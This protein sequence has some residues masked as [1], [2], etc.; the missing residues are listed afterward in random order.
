M[1]RSPNITIPRRPLCFPILKKKTANIVKTD[2]VSPLPYHSSIGTW[3]THI[4]LHIFLRGIRIAS[5]HFKLDA[6]TRNSNA[7]I[8]N[9]CAAWARS[10]SWDTLLYYIT[11]I[12][13]P[14]YVQQLCTAERYNRY[15]VTY[16]L[17]LWISSWYRYRTVRPFQTT[18]HTNSGRELWELDSLHLSNQ[19]S[20][21]MFNYIRTCLW[22][23][24]TARVGIRAQ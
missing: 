20:Q 16:P 22:C 14:H 5:W 17:C 11:V 18:K 7:L 6:T 23:S 8:P 2:L 10:L 4:E 9:L 15:N 24:C 12:R 21:E 1:R 19:L 3:Y 13:I